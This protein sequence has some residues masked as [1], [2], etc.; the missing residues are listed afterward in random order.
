[1]LNSLSFP[2]AES[3]TL[4]KKYARH[5][6]YLQTKGLIGSGGRKLQE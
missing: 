5:E 4:A 2:L 1:M 6:F 3:L